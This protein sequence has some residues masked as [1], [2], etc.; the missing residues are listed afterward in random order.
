MKPNPRMLFGN[1]F[2]DERIIPNY[3]A[4]FG[5]DVIAKLIQ[6]NTTNEYDTVLTPLQNTMIPLRRELGEVDTTLN[7]QVGKTATVDTFIVD[8]TKYMKDNYVFIAAALG[9]DKTP[10]ARICNL[11]CPEIGL[12]ESVKIWNDP[13]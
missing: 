1:I 9:G 12:H 13:R 4:R 2:D 11:S 3:L 7:T 10:I 6:N 5:D 8:F